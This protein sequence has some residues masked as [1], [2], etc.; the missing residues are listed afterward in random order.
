MRILDEQNNELTEEGLDLTLG[1]LIDDTIFIRHHDAEPEQEL[2]E[3]PDLENP[4]EEFENGGKIVNMITIQEYRPAIDA[5]DEYEA[6]KRYKLYTEDELATHEQMAKS[7]QF[8]K[9]GNDRLTEVESAN[10]DQDELLVDIADTVTQNQLDTD[11]ALTT[12]YE[13]MTG[14]T[15]E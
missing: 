11:E 1:Y 9:E 13:L 7:Q 10:L 15:N 2:I 14:E 5:W 3:E 8:L 6:V 4:V 12:L